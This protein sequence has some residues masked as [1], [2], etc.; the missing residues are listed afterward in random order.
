MIVKQL[1]LIGQENMNKKNYNL[2]F[3]TMVLNY[4]K[5]N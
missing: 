4:Q 1:L 5:K 3:Q 2:M